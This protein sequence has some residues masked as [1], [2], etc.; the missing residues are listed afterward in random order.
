VYNR[1]MAV[2]YESEPPRG[3]GGEP[4]PFRRADY[5]ALP[6]EPRC[7]LL[8]GHLV[9][10][11]APIALHQRVV[12]ALLKRLDE[13]AL[14]QGHLCLV[15]PMDVT[16]FD[17]TVLQPDLLIVARERREIAPKWVDGAPDLVV[18][19]LSP[20]TS[21]RDRMVKLALYA[22][23]GVPE[24]WIV[25]PEERT[26]ERLSLAGDAYRVVVTEESESGRLRSVRFPELAVELD[27]LW[28]EIDRALTGRL[29][30]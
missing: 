20:S 16:L 30:G 10:T 22:K 14:A 19:V 11:P 8:W 26:I 5:L 13:F 18:E 4:G 29:P 21:R 7:E 27:P 12:I 28:D 17:H 6:D 24:Y 9:V 3:V 1:F 15:A 23:A 2:V 25:D